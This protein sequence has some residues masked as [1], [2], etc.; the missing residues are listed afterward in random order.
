[1]VPRDKEVKNKEKCKKSRGFPEG[2]DLSPIQSVRTKFLEGL[3]PLRRRLVT[4]PVMK[5]ETNMLK[6]SWVEEPHDS[7]GVE[8]TAHC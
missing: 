5:N 2:I 3:S 4:S 6:L 7:D 8:A 1:M